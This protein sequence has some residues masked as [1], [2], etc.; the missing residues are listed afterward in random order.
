[1]SDQVQTVLGAASEVFTKIKETLGPAPREFLR[2][3]P[4]SLFLGTSTFALITQSFPLGILVLAMMELILIQVVLSSFI[5]GLQPNGHIASSDQCTTGL[6]SLYQITAVGKLLEITT[7]PSGPI[8]FVV[9]VLSYIFFSIL[10]FREELEEL[11]KQEPE[12]KA[13]L[14][15]SVVFSST[16]IVLFVVYRVWSGCDTTIPALGTT[17]FGFGAGYLVY[18]LHAYLFG[19]DSINML[20]LPLLA[21]RASGGRPLYVCAKQTPK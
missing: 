6:P 13:R 15:L 17:L 8:F 16:L 3:M 11:G 1:M 4:D 7:F 19:R 10:N 21:D 12:W 5:K 14:P 2:A 20:G 18:L 9:G